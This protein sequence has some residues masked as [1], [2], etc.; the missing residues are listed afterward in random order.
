MS[1]RDE[2]LAFLGLPA[3]ATLFEI[4]QAFAGRRKSASERLAAGDESVRVELAALSEAYARLTGRSLDRQETSSSA[5]SGAASTVIPDEPHLRP[6][7]WWESYL[8]L[9]LS[10]ASVT[11]LVTLAAYLPHIYRKGGFLIPLG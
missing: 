5:S 3:D 6:P 4:E 9:L 1:N 8:A 7:A 11:A 2:I 10:L